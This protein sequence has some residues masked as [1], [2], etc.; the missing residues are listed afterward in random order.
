MIS[1]LKGNL[2]ES[3]AQALVNTVNTQGVMGKGI[4]LQFKKLYPNNF[5]VYLE[6]CKSNDFNI[7]ELLVTKDNNVSTGEKIIV[8]FPTKKSWRSPSR[9]EYIVEGLNSL[10]KTIDNCEI[11]SIAIPP[12]GSGNGGLQWSKV[13]AIL[14]DKL[15]S[16]HD[17]DIYIYE[18]SQSVKEILKKER[19]KLTPARAMLLFMLFKLVRN[20]EFVSEFASEKLCYFL[21]RFGAETYFNLKYEPNFYGPYSGKIKHV[22]NHLNGSYIMGYAGKD[23]KPFEELD[24]IVDSWNE[25]ESYINSNSELKKI[26]TLTDDFLDGFYSP[27][28]LELLSTVDFISNNK[29]TSDPKTIEKELDSWSKRKRTLFSNDKFINISIT[30]LK[31]WNLLS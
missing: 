21:Q 3:K 18:P 9:Y 28:G 12:L 20:G 26:V 15:T 16:I 27:F 2:F 23:K 4:A 5:K 24:L 7:G 6:K 1:Y 10:I 17:C 8:N 31:K 11:K 13:K 22:L 30:H 14:E 29:N 19:V 25:V